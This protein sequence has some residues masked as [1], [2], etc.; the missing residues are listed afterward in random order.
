MANILIAYSSREGQTR[1]I[2]AFIANEIMQQ[3]HN[4]ETQE[5]EAMPADM[6]ID[7]FHAVMVGSA[8][9]IGKY[10]KAT[11]QFVDTCKPV[12]SKKT[13]AFFSVSM[14]ASSP[15]PRGQ[16]VAQGYIDNFL[17]QTRWTPDL[18]KSIS[19]ALVFSQ[20]GPIKTLLMKLITRMVRGE[21]DATRDQ[22]FTDWE[23]VSRFSQAF[24]E[25]LDKSIDTVKTTQTSLTPETHYVQAHPEPD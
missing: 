25:H 16:V 7:H 4:V 11:W 5:I 10:S 1:K 13:T 20:Y 9:H 12:L 2:S 21:V 24:M 23:D 3:G 17:M 14:S 19:G 18:H 8:I 22:E 6:P 15:K